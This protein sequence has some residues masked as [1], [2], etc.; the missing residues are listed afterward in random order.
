MAAI[1]GSIEEITLDDRPF[2]LAAD[3]EA[4]RILGGYENEVL[5]NGNRTSRLIKKIKQGGF[6]GMRLSCDNDRGDQE[7]VQDLAN[8]K[9]FFRMHLTG[10]DGTVYQGRCQITGD[11]QYDYQTATLTVN[12]M[13]DGVI[14]QQ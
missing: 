7:Y 12:L 13:F 8:A 6:D 5:P 3:S 1:G 9:R 4:A 10:T 2:T 14:T 11:I